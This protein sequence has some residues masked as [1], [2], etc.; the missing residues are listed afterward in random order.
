MH[1]IIVKTY[2]L[3]DA[4]DDS[5]M[6]RNLVY[7]RDRLLMNKRVMSLV[8]QG[9]ESKYDYEKIKV[10]K[11]LYEQDDYRNYM[12]N[13]NRLADIIREFNYRIRQITDSKRCFK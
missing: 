13:Y 3:L 5:E 2:E 11:E 4:L 1:D 6:M 8:K 10:K 12:D 9:Q 7:Y